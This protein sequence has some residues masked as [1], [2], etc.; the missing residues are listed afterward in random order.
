VYSEGQVWPARIVA[1]ASYDPK[2]ER[3]HA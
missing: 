1:P 2:G 3:M